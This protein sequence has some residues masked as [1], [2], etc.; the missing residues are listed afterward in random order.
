MCQDPWPRPGTCS[1]ALVLTVAHGEAMQ[2]VPDLPYIIYL[3]LVAAI[4]IVSGSSQKPKPC[5]TLK[6]LRQARGELDQLKAKVPKEGLEG[7]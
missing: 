7:F 3:N 1:E 4:A 5:K 2:E 6:L